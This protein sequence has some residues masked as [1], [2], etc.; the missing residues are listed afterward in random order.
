MSKDEV[1]V[2]QIKEIF[3]LM[4][5][6]LPGLLDKLTK[7]LYG[8]E[9]AERYAKAVAIFYK[10]LVEAGMTNEQAFQLTKDYMSNLAIGK[11]IGGMRGSEGKSEG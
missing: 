2:E 3:Q 11:M 7:V 10:G 5:E 8:T 9:E 4:E 6:K 1:D